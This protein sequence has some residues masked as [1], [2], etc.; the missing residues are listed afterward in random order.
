[1]RGGPSPEARDG[2]LHLERGEELRVQDRVLVRPLRTLPGGEREL[3]QQDVVR[4]PLG[5][6]LVAA[7]HGNVQV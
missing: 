1:M 7:Q 2:L 3:L 4:V 6:R 5:R